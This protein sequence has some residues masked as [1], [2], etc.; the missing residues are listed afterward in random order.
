MEGIPKKK[1]EDISGKDG[2]VNSETI[3]SK[4]N[5]DPLKNFMRRRSEVPDKWVEYQ[6]RR[7]KRIKEEKQ[8]IRD[9]ISNLTIEE[10]TELYVNAICK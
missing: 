3:K 7:Q 2:E 9:N 4:E 1:P 5:Y 8:Q 6:K 10:L